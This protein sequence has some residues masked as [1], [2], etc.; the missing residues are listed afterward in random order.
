M[1]DSLFREAQEYHRAGALAKAAEL[2]QRVLR[3]TPD[4]FGALDS[5]GLLCFQCGQFENA[6]QLFDSAAKQRPNSESAVYN[7]GCALQQLKRADEALAAFEK[8]LALNSRH[9]GA[10]VNRAV[11]F[12]GLNR[13]GEALENCEQALAARP[14]FPPALLNRA[15]AQFALGH[16]DAALA[17]YEQVLTLAPDLKEASLGRENALFELRQADRAPTDFLRRLYDT[18]SEYYD[19]QMLRTLGYCG[20][21]KLRVLADRA[22][23]QGRI[24][25]RILDIGC[26]TGLAG[27]AFKDWVQGGRLDGIDLSQKM[28]D[29]AKARHIYDSLTLADLNQALGAAS[30]GYDVVLAADLLIYFGDFG[31]CFAGVAR[32]L[33]P[34]G[35]FLLTVESLTDGTWELAATRRYRHSA[36]YIE[37]EATRHGL[38]MVAMEDFTI[39]TE[40]AIPVPALAVI[41]RASKAT[42]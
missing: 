7:R 40:A 8:T 5:L 27:D 2:Y 20:H 28:L 15:N 29:R 42:E 22:F 41:L 31:P 17:D 13:A 35:I 19:E 1:Q 3:A 30:P 38:E 25:Q 18:F 9:V 39:R 10:L 4:H 36:R 24:A 26:G 11:I 21:T 16:H 23:P 37:A 12:L 33:K 6:A 32:I 14:N 34:G